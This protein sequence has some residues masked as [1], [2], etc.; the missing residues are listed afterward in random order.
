MQIAKLSIDKQK[1][2]DYIMLDSDTF[3]NQRG[4]DVRPLRLKLNFEF[5][6]QNF[7][8]ISRL[9]IMD[10]N[11]YYQLKTPYEMTYICLMSIRKVTI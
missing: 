8:N 5:S 6:L 11:F 1:R 7:N 3:L 2:L 9:K 10:I 4:W